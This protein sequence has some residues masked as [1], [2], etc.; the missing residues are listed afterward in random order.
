MC[1]D[2]ACGAAQDDYESLFEDTAVGN[3][4]ITPDSIV[5]RVNRRLAT[6][7]GFTTAEV[8]G[9]RFSDLLT[10]GGKIYLETHL[11]PMLR[12]SGAFEEVMLEM[13]TADGGKLPVLVNGFERRDAE[14]RP[15]LTR[16]AVVRA[17][18]R[19][20]YEQNLRQA[21]KQARDALTNAEGT[22]LDERQTAV[23][24]EQFIAVLGHDLRNPL[25]AFNAGL[26]VLAKG[27]LDERQARV[28]PLM[29]AAVRR[30]A[31]LIDDVMNLARGRLGGGIPINRTETDLAPI[32][33]QVV[34]EVAGAHP[35]RQIE[36]D[37]QLAVNVDCD[38]PKIAQLAS[39][40]L[41]NA[42]SH[43]AADGPIKISAGSVGAGFELAVENVGNPIPPG[44]L[45][46]LFEPFTREA[47]DG[48]EGLGLGLYIA[49]EIAKAHGGS[50]TAMSDEEKTVFRL[51]LG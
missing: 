25:A 34:D 28:I 50:L 46:R 26:R 29:D 36:V 43:G 5:S 6:W 48:K 42:I 22:L 10:V 35:E 30:M 31:G 16:I 14:G 24:R 18:H 13:R 15:V 47:G 21:R 3:I 45:T 33:Q 7:L 41:A 49:S 12:M 32:L 23:L 9:K 20:L 1:G 8:V 40:L 2:G 37:F 51:E 4:I 44:A 11:A 17:S 38:G 27:Q 19:L 39:N